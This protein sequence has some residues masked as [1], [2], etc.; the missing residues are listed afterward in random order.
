MFYTLTQKPMTEA[1]IHACLKE[2]DELRRLLADIKV[3]ASSGKTK[4]ETAYPACVRI[5]NLLIKYDNRPK[6][7]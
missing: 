4:P 5:F 6:Q 3:Y 1:Q 7:A 2:R